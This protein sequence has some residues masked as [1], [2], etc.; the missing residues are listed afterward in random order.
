MS[1]DRSVLQKDELW[2]ILVD[3]VHSLPMYKNHIRYVEDVMVKERPDMPPQELAVQ[4][5]I[6]LG[7]AIVILD[8]VLGQKLGQNISGAAASS[9]KTSE[10]TLL[11]FG[12]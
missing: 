7:E 6:P 8:E 11:D 3:T 12:S 10:R 2:K 4:L 1:R 5:N 9:S